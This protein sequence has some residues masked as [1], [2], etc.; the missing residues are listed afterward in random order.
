MKK[1]FFLIFVLFL[2]SCKN[3]GTEKKIDSCEVSGLKLEL[4]QNGKAVKLQVVGDDGTIEGELKVDSPCYFVRENEN[5]QKFSYE[6]MGIDNVVI[7]MGNIADTKTKNNYGISD[8]NIC[9]TLAQGILIKKDKIIL[10]EKIF[11][12]GIIC[13]DIGTDE[14]NFWDFAH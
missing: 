5:I 1:N 4:I 7:I 9:G 6:D 12:G 2:F 8:E 11:K 3:T 14:K 13:K 10:T